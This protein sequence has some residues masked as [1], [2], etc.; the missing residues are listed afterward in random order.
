MRKV[1]VMAGGQGSRLWPLTASRPKPLVPVANRPVLAYILEW[2]RGHDFPEVLMTLHHRADAIRRAFGDGRSFGLGITYQV[3]SEPLGTAGAVKQAGDWIGSEPFLV[4]SGDA[5]T[6][7]DLGALCRRH[8]ETG[9]CLTLGL[10]QVPDASEYGVVAL[11][12]RGRVTRFQ[13]KP[14]PGQAFSDL[15]NTGIYC[16]D[17]RVLQRVPPGRA[18]D[19]SRDVFPRLLAEG[20]PLFGCVAGGYWRDIG[21]LDSYRRGQRDALEGA[22]RVALPATAASP[23]I[24]V[25]YDARI[26]SAA[27]VGGPVLFGAGCRIE[28]GVRVLPGSVIGGGTI[29]HRHACVWEAVVG[30]GC[31]IGPGAV[32]RDCILDEGVRVGSDCW[33]GEGAVIGRGRC[34]TSGSRIGKGQRLEPDRCRTYVSAGLGREGGREEEEMRSP[35][36]S[37]SVALP[38]RP[39]L[40]SHRT[41][42]GCLPVARQP[43]DTRT[44]NPGGIR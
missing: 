1:I 32:V 8:Q 16:V 36:D 7:L 34:L 21:T 15:A 29:V 2:L 40:G 31:E 13:E 30:A 20:R 41:G 25:G 19:W 12:G 33:V 35:N 28:P 23:G 17:P 38:P 37:L 43:T 5:L 44:S 14:G 3:E 18:C 11:D 42:G 9:A 4:V 39:T 10:K 26:A 6:D 22:V 24:W 27:M